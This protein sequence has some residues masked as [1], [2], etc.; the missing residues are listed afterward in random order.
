VALALAG[1]THVRSTELLSTGTRL[2]VQGS[3]GGAGLRGLEHEEPT[4]IQA[5]VLYFSKADHRLQ[6]WDDVTLGGLGEQSV[7]IQRHLEPDPR[8]TIFP[9]PGNSPSPTVATGTTT[10]QAGTTTLAP[11]AN[12][13]YASE[14]PDG[15]RHG[16]GQPP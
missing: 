4:P 12:V 1:H 10:P 9:E 16:P 5:S 11:R 14:V 6:A 7:Q 3:T 15:R 8:R 13:P 2:M